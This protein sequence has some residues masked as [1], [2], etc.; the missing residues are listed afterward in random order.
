MYRLFCLCLHPGPSA[1]MPDRQTLTH[2][3]K[4]KVTMSLK[5]WFTTLLQGLAYFSSTESCSCYFSQAAPVLLLSFSYHHS[6]SYSSSHLLYLKMLLVPTLTLTARGKL[7]SPQH[8]LCTCHGKPISSSC[9]INPASVCRL[10]RACIL[11]FFFFFNWG[12]ERRGG[13]DLADGV[14]PSNFAQIQ[15]KFQ[16]VDLD[17]AHFALLLIKWR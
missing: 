2:C 6:P 1:P 8:R 14:A 5:R 17:P 11:F 15:V 13:V 4:Y 9:P 16:K 3:W 7:A 10:F 12:K